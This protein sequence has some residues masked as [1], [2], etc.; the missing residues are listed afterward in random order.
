MTPDVAALTTFT[1]GVGVLK[2]R[3]VKK[4][5]TAGK[6]FG[7][8]D[9]D[10]PLF[11]LAEMYLIYA[12]ATVRSGGNTG[13]AV[14]YINLLRQ[15]AYGNATGNITAANLTLNFILDERARELYWEGFRRTDL[16]RYGVFTSNAYLWTWKGG[17]KNGRSVQDIRA[18]YPIPSADLNVN[19]NLTQN[20]GY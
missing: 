20:P 10:F 15:R 19:P 5:G 7:H 1:N 6:D 17:V 3:N 14:N 4:D 9:A 2:Y 11:R 16:I 13:T 18:L 8:S 12:E